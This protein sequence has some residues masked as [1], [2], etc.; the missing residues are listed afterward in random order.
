MRNWSLLLL[1]VI[2]YSAVPARLWG[3]SATEKQLTDLYQ[4]LLTADALHDTTAFTEVL[5]PT[6]RFIT[7]RGDTV[8]TRADRIERAATDTS[9]RSSP[10]LQS[11]QFQLYGPTAVG[12]CRYTGT[13]RSS[14][15]DSTA[16]FVSLVVF[17]QRGGRWQIIASHPSAV[18]AK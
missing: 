12:Q 1:G 10:P 16:N 14:V 11:C 5:A 9:H 4:R 17:N 3:Q 18:R 2:A 15:G 7:L 13:V 6:Y 8:L